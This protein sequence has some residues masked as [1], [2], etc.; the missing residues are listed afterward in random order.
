MTRLYEDLIRFK[1]YFTDAYK[2]VPNESFYM[3]AI[4]HKYCHSI[5]VLNAGRQ[6][7]NTPELAGKT[8]EFKLLAERALLFHDVGRFEE[9]AQR[10]NAEQENREIL[11]FTSQINHGDIGYEL[12]KNHPIYG[13]I[14]ILFAVKYH[15]QMIENVYAS[16]LWKEVE[17]SPY[18]TEVKQILFL[19]RDADKLANLRSIKNKG[20]LKEDVF[21]KQLSDEAKTAGISPQVYT[22]FFDKKVILTNTMRTFSDRL[23]MLLSWISD[24]NYTSMR[25]IFVKEQYTEYVINELKKCRVSV[26]E[27]GKI[28]KFAKS[29][30]PTDE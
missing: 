26:D 25:Q 14:R 7:F 27:T 15:G 11:A 21:Y 17:K 18:K 19:V 30:L 5:D 4:K 13:D 2:K 10:Y 1:Q 22:Q 12:L 8:A 28:E 23:L 29:F 20:H 16:D 24:L 6:I 9:N 3:S